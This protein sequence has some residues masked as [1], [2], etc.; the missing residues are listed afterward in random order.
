MRYQPSDRYPDITF[1]RKRTINSSNDSLS[2][3]PRIAPNLKSLLPPNYLV[4]KGEDVKK[5]NRNSIRVFDLDDPENDDIGDGNFGYPTGHQFQSG[6]F[7][8]TGISLKEDHLNYFFKL[9]FRNLVDPGWHAEYGFQLTFITIAINSSEKNIPTTLEV[10]RNSG[11]I[12][13]EGK[14][15]DRLIHIGGGLEVVDTK[16]KILAQYIPRQL[17]Y[18]LGNATLG[19]ISFALPRSLFNGDVEDWMITVLVGSQDD[20]GGGGIGEFRNVTEK[21]G[22]WKGSGGGKGSSNVN[23]TLYYP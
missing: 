18:P 16:G 4:L 21:G 17:Q 23:D 15:A 22:I 11:W 10:G 19:E 7:D 13:G 14:Q 9:N 5:V 20:H 1:E 12:L 3:V 2:L 8:L 6:I